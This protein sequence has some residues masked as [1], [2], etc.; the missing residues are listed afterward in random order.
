MNGSLVHRITNTNIVPPSIRLIF[1]H[2]YSREVTEDLIKSYKSQIIW[3]FEH[4]LI[5]N[6]KS[7]TV[8]QKNIRFWLNCFYSNYPYIYLF[9]R[10]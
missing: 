9:L 4:R 8:L 7:L 10:K 3:Q 2:Y 5:S 1:R 6:M